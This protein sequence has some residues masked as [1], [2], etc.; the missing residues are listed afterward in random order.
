MAA[1]QYNRNEP[2]EKDLVEGMSSDK[3]SQKVHKN[4]GNFANDRARAAKAGSEGGKA[5]HSGRR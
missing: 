2:V 5:S 3:S 1:T 4:P